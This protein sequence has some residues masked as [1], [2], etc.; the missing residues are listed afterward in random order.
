MKRPEKC[1]QCLQ[2]WERHENVLQYKLGQCVK[3]KKKLGK[4]G[5]K[6]PDEAPLETLVKL[7]GP[8][9]PCP[10][11][12][13]FNFT[14]KTE[15]KECGSPPSEIVKCM[16][17]AQSLLKF[18]VCPD[19]VKTESEDSVFYNT[20]I[21]LDGDS[22]ERLTCKG[23]WENDLN[24]KEI[25]MMGTL[26]FRYKLSQCLKLKSNFINDLSALSP[27]QRII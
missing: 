3:N 2:V 10:F 25:Y 27:P 20:I 19:D 24:D 8:S 4:E 7:D 11:S 23:T 6:I 18:E 14:Y 21:G 13:A 12:G 9:A 22:Q 5:C 15:G 26:D 16:S 1:F 17:P